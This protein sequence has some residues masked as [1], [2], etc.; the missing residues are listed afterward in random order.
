[1]KKINI[2]I[3][4]LIVIGSLFGVI[5]CAGGS[6]YKP[7]P[8]V[9]FTYPV[10][11]GMI[12]DKAERKAMIDAKIANL[13]ATN[14]IY[15]GELPSD[16]DTLAM[17]Y[18][19]IWGFIRSNYAAFKGIA[20][21]KSNPKGIDWDKLGEVGY[22]EAQYVD[23]YG[24]FAR[25]LTHMGWVLN[26]GHT[27]IIT[28]RIIDA[29]DNSRKGKSVSKSPLFIALR[30]RG[31]GACYTVTLKDELVV[32]KNLNENN[33]Y[34]L[35]P[36]DE[37]VG[38]NGVPW[39]EWLPRIIDSGLPIFG[40]PASNK[41]AVKDQLMRSAVTNYNFFEKVNI[42]RYETGEIETMDIVYVDREDVDRDYCPDYI[43]DV[44]G[45]ARPSL[46]K[47]EKGDVK[48]VEV[49]TYGKV[50]IDGAKIGYA[51]ITSCPS[52]FED[53]D[54]TELWD[55]YETKWSKEFDKIV[56]ELKE[57][58]DGII[59]DLRYN[60]GGR[61]ETFYLGMSKLI[62]AKKDMNMFTM[63]GRNSQ[64]PNILALEPGTR[65]ES[66]LKADPKNSYKK[67]MVVLT[68]PNCISACDFLMA[69]F[70]KFPKQ[71]KII[72]KAHNGSFT[73][74]SDRAYDVGEDV[75]YQYI[76][77]QAG[78]YWTD[79]KPKDNKEVIDYDLLIRRNFV[80]E[81]VWQTKDSIAK[82]ED[83]VRK[84]AVEIIK[85]GRIK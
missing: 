33:P 20:K 61:N 55:P 4:T 6:N 76:P 26:E 8:Y 62:D 60:T 78:A 56:T 14:E 70:A 52:G 23:N 57:D 59:F 19:S 47:D 16:A 10:P 22:E 5:M 12:T 46:I 42:K 37:I 25:M 1:M 80:Q 24:Q 21:T 49:A 68:G 31:L 81:K 18:Q 28:Q 45:V 15:W 7:A 83:L 50:T 84:R 85:S 48:G 40:S 35:K 38:F 44:E 9:E 30:S 53:F 11:D 71:F 72:G 58:T 2:L 75:V 13:E 79:R 67:P 66:P 69:F 51:Y 63:L 3:T 27:N 41:K 54:S 36:G 65:K 34:K 17:A 77:S 39:S 73:G 29:L 74:V 82:G 32:T 64:N 43:N